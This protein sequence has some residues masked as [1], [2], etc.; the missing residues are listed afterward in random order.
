MESQE[1]STLPP[2][3]VSTNE[4]TTFSTNTTETPANTF[5]PPPSPKGFA[6]YVCKSEEDPDCMD[7]PLQ[8]KFEKVCST[9]HPGHE[10]FVCRKKIEFLA[11]IDNWGNPLTRVVRLCGYL[12]EPEGSSDQQCRK[13]QA[14]KS[15]MSSCDCN[16][17]LCNAANGR[18]GSVL[19]ML[20]TTVLSLVL[21]L[22]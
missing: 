20:I 10:G 15:S 16:E 4:I 7:K 6:C 19:N 8:S 21:L 17:S 1:V 12:Q 18:M 14:G 11:T 13:H 2:T 9:M 22:S 3:E 5:S